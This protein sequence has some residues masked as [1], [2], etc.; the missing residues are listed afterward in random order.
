[1]ATPVKEDPVITQ[2]LV[3]HLTLDQLAPGE[4]A[5]IVDVDAGAPMGRRLLDVGI[6]PGVRARVIRRAP[7][8]DPM[9]ICLPDMLVSL[10]SYEAALV[11]V[12]FD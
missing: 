7:L 5:V 9:E 2:T 8:G 1:M 12:Q 3:H 10:R 11:R 4:S 6:A